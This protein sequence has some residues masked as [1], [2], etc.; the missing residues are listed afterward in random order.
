MS[1]NGYLSTASYIKSEITTI[2]TKS[3]DPLT[4]FVGKTIYSTGIEIIWD[5][6]ESKIKITNHH[7]INESKKM[8]EKRINYDNYCTKVI[9]SK[10]NEVKIST[11]L[12]SSNSFYIQRLVK[13]NKSKMLIVKSA[14]FDPIALQKVLFYMTYGILEFSLDEMGQIMRV[15]VSYEM[16]NVMSTIE[17]S[18]TSFG[19]FPPHILAKILSIACHEDYLITIKTKKIILKIVNE[20]LCKFLQSKEFFNL[21]PSALVKL[22]SFD[23]L[24]V[25]DEVEVFRISMYYLIVGNNQLYADPILNC[26]RFRNMDNIEVKAVYDISEAYGDLYTKKILGY[27]IENYLLYQTNNVEGKVR[28]MNILCKRNKGNGNISIIMKVLEKKYFTLVKH[29]S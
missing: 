10:G 19:S 23:D 29:D 12:F 17:L 8:E 6:V 3:E 2:S 5:V 20:N 1:Q 4:N 9:L 14:S 24:G 21:S 26:V 28:N 11:D 16:P 13:E 7:F 15:A 18:L 27:Y 25:I 22:L